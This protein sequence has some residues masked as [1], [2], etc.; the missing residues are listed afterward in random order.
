MFITRAALPRRTV[1]RGM[2]AMVALPLLDAMAPALTALARTPAKPVRRIGFVYIPN[3]AAMDSWTPVETGEGFR[4]SPT[5]QSLEP[6]RDQVVVLSNL[7]HANAESENDG[8]GE[9]A[10][11]SAVYLTG[12]RAKKTAGVEVRAGTTVD[13]LIA[14]QIGRD[15][16]LSSLELALDSAEFVGDCDAGYACAYVNTIA[17]RSPTL[18]LPMEMNPRVVFERLFGDGASAEERSR[19]NRENASILDAIGAKV[20]RLSGRLGPRDRQKLDQYLDSI[21]D[22]ERRIQLVESRNRE[23][24]LQPPA[25]PLGVPETFDEHMT[26]MYDLQVV[27]FQADLTRV[28][29][30]L[31]GRETTTRTYPSIGVPEGHHNLS[32]HQYNPEKIAKLARVNAYHV[33]G[34]A[35]FLEKLRATPDGDGSLLDHSLLL[36]GGGMADPQTH[37]HYPLPVVLAG[38]GAGALRGGRHLVYP[39]RTPMSSL[40]LSLLDKFG[41]PAEQFGNAAGVTETLPDV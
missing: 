38:G 15:T 20:G 32:H 8:A 4:F 30:L 10:R 41:A 5:L 37:A 19:I 29:T 25:T 40:L 35:S 14:Q 2:G 34:F 3:G 23:N 21:R 22:V 13:Q 24:A 11:S 12:V 17:W 27:A 9:H 36:Y 39:H 7:G 26:L 31:L 33:Q 1:L 16:P 28:T 6:L 18:P